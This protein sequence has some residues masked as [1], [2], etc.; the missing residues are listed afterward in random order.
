MTNNF[1]ALKRLEYPGRVIILGSNPEGTDAVMYAI[2]GRSPSSQARRLLV[3]DDQKHVTVTPTD[4]KILKSGNPDLLIYHS[5]IINRGI[6]VSNGKQTVD[7]PPHF[8]TGALSVAVLD[9]ALHE[10]EY[11][12]DEPNYTPRISGCVFGGAALSVIKRDA[13]GSLLRIFYELPRIQGKGKLIATYTGINT[14]PLPSFTGEPLDVNIPFPTAHEAALALYDALA[15]A[16]GKDD[17]RVAAA[18]VYKNE[19]GE[20]SVSVKNRHESK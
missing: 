10:W 13:N 5:I 16:A 18:A 8:K 6:A 17:Y 4:E 12:P 9:H 15:P 1:D 19:K 3:S 7:I 14:D 11:E 2:T 20:I